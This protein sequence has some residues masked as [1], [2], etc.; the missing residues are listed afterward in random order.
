MIATIRK[1]IDSD[2]QE[3]M[4]LFNGVVEEGNAFLTENNMTTAQMEYWLKNEET[5]AY[6]ALSANRIVGCY[7]L[8][9]NLK[10]RGKHVGNATY[11]ISK[12]FR[13]HGIGYQLGKHSLEEAKNIGFTAMQFNS[14]VAINQSSKNRWLKLGF[15]VIGVIPNG[16]RLLNETFVDIMILYKK[17]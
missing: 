1:Y 15:Q 16:Y 7:M 10:G 14:V 3:I 9:P 12:S 5:A 11:F 2:I 6:V 8:R 4:N 17:L 13:G